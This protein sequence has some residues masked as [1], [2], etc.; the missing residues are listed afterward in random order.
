MTEQDRVNQEQETQEL[1]QNYHVSERRIKAA[2]IDFIPLV[3]LFAAT[4][5]ALLDYPATPTDRLSI[6]HNILQ[7]LFL[8]RLG[9]LCHSG[10]YHF[11]HFGQDDHGVESR[12]AQRQTLW[13]GISH[14]EEHSARCRW[15][16]LF[17]PHWDHLYGFDQA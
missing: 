15:A 12:Q 6:L 1:P 16:T 4:V 11:Y 7:F 9:I 13:V 14:L 5:F 2:F 17:L 3:G 8:L 10:G